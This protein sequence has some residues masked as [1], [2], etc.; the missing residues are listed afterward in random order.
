M[1]EDL[2]TI[3]ILI[4]QVNAAGGFKKLADLDKVREAF[5]RIY[6]S[7]SISDENES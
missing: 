2:K 6:N 7:V 3:E 4:E 5:N 1:K